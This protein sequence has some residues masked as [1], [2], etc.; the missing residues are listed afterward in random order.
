MSQGDTKKNNNEPSNVVKPDS[1]IDPRNKVPEFT[2]PEH[3]NQ[4]REAGYDNISQGAI[5]NYDDRSLSLYCLRDTDSVK[6][7]QEEAFKEALGDDEAT[8]FKGD[9][10]SAS[11][12]RLVSLARERTVNNGILLQCLVQVAGLLITTID[13]DGESS[14]THFRTRL[15]N[16]F[17]QCYKNYENTTK[18]T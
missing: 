15:D 12:G 8:E 14:P 5:L 6:W 16:A 11:S 3:Q 17:E 2:D 9:F 7:L 1:G 4:L 18:L 10:A 13:K